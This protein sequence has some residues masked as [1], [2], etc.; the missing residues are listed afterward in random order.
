[1]RYK[2]PL[3]KSRNFHFPND[4]SDN[5]RVI[6]FRKVDWMDKYVEVIINCSDEDIEVPMKGETLFERHYIDTALLQ[7]GILIRKVTE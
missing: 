2:E 1:M 7:N 4:V 6:Q 5:P 3:L